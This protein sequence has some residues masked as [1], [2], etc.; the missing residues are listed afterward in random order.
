[1]NKERC[2]GNRIGSTH[3]PYRCN[4]KHLHFVDDRDR[5]VD[6]PWFA[7]LWLKVKQIMKKPKVR[8]PVP[9]PTQVRAD[10]RRPALI[11][12]GKKELHYDRSTEDSHR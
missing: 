10:K 2:F 9:K 7:A 8:I 6:Y 12:I 4:Y 11:A 3:Y 5:I 1:M